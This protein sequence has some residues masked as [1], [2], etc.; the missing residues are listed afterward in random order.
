LERFFVRHD[1][2]AVVYVLL[3]S[4]AGLTLAAH[5]ASV[6]AAWLPFGVAVF[7]GVVAAVLYT[8]RLSLSGR[9]F[10]TERSE[11]RRARQRIE[12]VAIP[13]GYAVGAAA[14]GIARFA[15][16]PVRA[17]VVGFACAGLLGL[18]PG[19]LANWVR[20]RRQTRTSRRDA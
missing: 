13:L 16:N 12:S 9:L 15:S 11:T 10:L 3:L 19:L 7:V 14:L 6:G 17:A 20:L 5:W 1:W 18:W 8:V 2:A 4:L